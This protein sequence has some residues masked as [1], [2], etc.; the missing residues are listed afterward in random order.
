MGI[1][2]VEIYIETILLSV[3]NPIGL[4]YITRRH[5]LLV[6][7]GMATSLEEGLQMRRRL[8]IFDGA[9]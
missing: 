2:G 7:M 4:R 3:M 9:E 6:C 5:S 8:I 1:F